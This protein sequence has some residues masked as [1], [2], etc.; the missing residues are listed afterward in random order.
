MRWLQPVRVSMIRDANL[1]MLIPQTGQASL[2]LQLRYEVCPYD[3]AQA[4]D[5]KE[6]A[7]GEYG[8]LVPSARIQADHT[9]DVA[10]GRVTKKTPTKKQTIKQEHT[11]DDNSFSFD[12]PVDSNTPSFSMDD[13]MFTGDFNVEDND[14][15]V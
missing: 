11:I 15:L 8:D 5:A 3:S 10:N 13:T 1:E 7:S 2:T 9:P 6:G 14:F 4:K 12:D